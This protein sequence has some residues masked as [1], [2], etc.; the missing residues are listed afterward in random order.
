MQARGPLMIEHRLIERMIETMRRKTKE[1][2]ESGVPDVRFIDVAVDF[3]RTYADRLHHGKEEDLLFPVL[4]SRGIPR[5]GGPIG[6]MLYEHQVARGLTREMAGALTDARSGDAAPRTR[7][8][9]A[10]R[11]YVD[12]LTSHIFKE[13]T[14]L[15][16]MGDRMMNPDDRRSLATQFCAVNCRAFEGRRREELQQIADE[17]EAEWRHG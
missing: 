12:L 7:F 16:E 14:V 11:Q 4:E 1:V 5:D 17:L 9:R 13:D 3:I 2:E 8:C 10:A 6:V 15:F